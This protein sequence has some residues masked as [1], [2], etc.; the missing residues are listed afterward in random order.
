MAARLTSRER[1]E[2]YRQIFLLNHSFDLI[3]Q[4]LN[5]LAKTCIFTARDIRCSALWIHW[6]MMIGAISESTYCYGKAA[7]RS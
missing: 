7:E 6:S 5:A 4:R 2:I 3:V 1:A